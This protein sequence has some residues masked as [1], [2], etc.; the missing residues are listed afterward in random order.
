MGLIASIP[1]LLCCACQT[2]S[3][4]CSFAS[5][6]F[7]ANT[8]VNFTAAKLFYVAMLGLSTI[9]ASILKYTSHDWS[10]NLGPFKASFGCTDSSNPENND[11]GQPEIDNYLLNKLGYDGNLYS[12]SIVA[13]CAGDAAV[14]RIGLTL[15]SFF[16]AMALFGSTNEGVFKGYWGI[17]LLCYGLAMLG[18]FFLPEATF[19]HGIFQGI[20][21]FS[22]S[23][24]LILQILILIDFAYEWNEQWVAK[25]YQDAINDYDEP[26]QKGWL[27]ALIGSAFSLYIASVVGIVF[28]FMYYGNTCSDSQAVISITLILSIGATLLTLFRNQIVGAEG[29]IL[30]AA[31]V[32]VYS[33]YLTWTG[34]QANPNDDCRPSSSQNSS[35]ITTGFLVAAL[36]LMWTSFRATAQ[37]QNLLRGENTGKGDTIDSSTSGINMTTPLYRVEEGTS[38]KNISNLESGTVTTTTTTEESQVEVIQEDM[39]GESIPLFFLLLVVASLYMTMMFTN[40]G[41]ASNENNYQGQTGYASMWVKIS[42]AWLSIL[43]YIWTLIAPAV[44]KDREFD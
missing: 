20:A 19:S 2:L 16:L 22:S 39:E 28:L 13:Y 10:S 26:S 40:W 37:T 35:T 12:T 27:I 6:C 36:S 5:C 23:I 4:A 9:L 17:K 21:R 15:S 33:I 11:N 3:C 38:S 1:S 24:F 32:V 42:S 30:P 14:N 18:C 43:L 29:A 31:V 25:A 44:C 34:L 41:E 8:G 7:Q